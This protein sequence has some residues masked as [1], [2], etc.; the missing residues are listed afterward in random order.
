[1][2]QFILN[3]VA[4][5]VGGLILIWVASLLSREA[6][7]ILT[8][9]LGR[10]LHIDID[11]VFKNKFDAQKDLTEEIKQAREVCVLTGR[12]NELQ[13]EVFASLFH[14]KPQKRVVKVGILLPRTECGQGE[15]DWTWQ[16]EM[17]LSRFDQAY[18]NGLLRRQIEATELFVQRQ[19]ADSS[20]EMR[21][22]NFPHVGRI[23]ITDRYLYYTP[24]R[25]DIHGRDSKVYKFRSG[26]EMYDNYLR[27]FEQ[28]W[29]ADAQNQHELIQQGSIRET[30]I[31][32]SKVHTMVEQGK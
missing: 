31:G 25:D 13:R 27:L 7:W 5:I 15:Y 2:S 14:E 24:Y 11:Y 32:A 8:G 19:P 20:I 29:V 16:R 21:R 30:E 9:I 26:G 6:R 1:M 12:G 18:G 10:L 22:Y 4:G 28:L 17:E 3:V 23:I